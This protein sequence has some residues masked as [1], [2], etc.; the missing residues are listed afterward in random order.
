[1]ARDA[2]PRAVRVVCTADDVSVV[3]ADG[4]RIDIPLKNFAKL[5]YATSSQRANYEL[6]GDG[7]G[8]HWP[9]ADEDISVA[10]L[11]DAAE[12]VHD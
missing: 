4:R 8:I 5:A 10:R 12:R 3:L 1:M 2:M 6:L 9:D 11:V 7:S